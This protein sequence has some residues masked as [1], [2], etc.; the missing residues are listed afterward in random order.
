MP[1]LPEVETTLRG[2]QPFIINCRVK[3]ISIRQSRLRWHVPSEL[4]RLLEGLKF[5]RL[6]RRGKYLLF[7][8]ES[9]VMLIHLGMSGSLRIVKASDPLGKHDH[10]D[11]CF[12]NGH[13]LRF[14]DPRRFGCV[15]WQ[16]KNQGTHP[17]LINLGPE[18]LSDDFGGD[19]LFYS[20][21]NRSVPIKSFIMNSKIVVGVGNI[22]ANEALFLARINPKIHAGKISQKRYQRLACSI[23]LVLKEAIVAGGTTLRDFTNSDGNPGY[24]RQSLNVYG[25]GGEKCRLCR[26]KL[27]EIQLVQRSTVYCTKCQR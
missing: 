17:L 8:N 1:E 13:I 21:R 9:G 24:F 26:N 18:P 22:Y 20:S 16:N 2:I 5:R 19:Y 12:D 6:A 25:R 15:L 7:E 23:R 14:R 4:P 10:I 11:F 27:C 3:K